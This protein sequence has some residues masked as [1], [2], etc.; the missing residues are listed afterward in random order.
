MISPNAAPP[1][2]TFR[3]SGYA[4]RLNFPEAMTES[5]ERAVGGLGDVQKTEDL[6]LQ[7]GELGVEQLHG[8][9]GLR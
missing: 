9:A 4:F 6:A 3:T 5:G 1:R 2:L 7:I 8:M